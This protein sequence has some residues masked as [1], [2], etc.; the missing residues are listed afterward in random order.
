M[1]AAAAEMVARLNQLDREFAA[2]PH[3]ICGAASVFVG[4]L[5]AGEIYNQYPQ[6]AWL[7]GTRAWLPGTDP[8][9]VERDFPRGSTNLPPIR[10]RPLRATG[11]RSE[12][13]SLSTLPPFRCRVSRRLPGDL[14]KYP[15]AHWAQAIC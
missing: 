3:P 5:H 7:E 12:T 14:G 8:S 13:H 2:T 11:S 4:Q 10:A 6:S 15:L 1:I 9:G